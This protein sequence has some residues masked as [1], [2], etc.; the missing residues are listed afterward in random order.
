[1]GNK[2]TPIFLHRRGSGLLLD[3]PESKEVRLCVCS[4]S[5]L[6]V[7]GAQSLREVPNTRVI[8]LSLFYRGESRGSNAAPRSPT[9]R[10]GLLSP[11]Y[12]AV[13]VGTER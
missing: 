8:S 4:F 7:Y 13:R 11:F 2:I 5:L 10:R 1:M 9:P 12:P 3:Q 6:S